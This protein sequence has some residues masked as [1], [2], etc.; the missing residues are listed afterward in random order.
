LSPNPDR[1]KDAGSTLSATSLTRNNESEERSTTPADLVRIECR[2]ILAAK[3]IV[4]KTV[5]KNHQ[6][7]WRLENSKLFQVRFARLPHLF[8]RPLTRPLDR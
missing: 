3:V 6:P 1:Q 7:G 4:A 2:V 8:A 5:L